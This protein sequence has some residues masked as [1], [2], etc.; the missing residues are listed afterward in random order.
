VAVDVLVTDLTMSGELDG[1]GLIRE[2]RRLRPGLPAILVTGL[3]G[4]ATP[5]RCKRVSGN[6]PS[7]VLQKPVTAEAL[8]PQVLALRQGTRWEMRASA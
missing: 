5:G 2:A 8:D 4:D 7:A 6:A 1:L 3:S